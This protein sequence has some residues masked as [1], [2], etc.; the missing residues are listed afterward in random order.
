MENKFG[1]NWTDKKISIVVDYTKA[2][3]T[4]MNKYP[5]F[6]CLY[7]DGFAGSG[8]IKKTR[9]ESEV[10]KG[11]AIRV[12]EID[13]PKEFD[14]YYFVEKKDQFKKQLQEIIKEKFPKKKT[15]VVCGDCNEK[16]FSLSAYLKK[17]KSY[18]VLA[19]IDPFGMSVNWASLQALQGLGIDL[20]ILVPTGI[21]VNRLLKKDGNISEAWLL[22]LENFLGISREEILKNFYRQY[23][24]HNLFDDE[25]VTIQ[26]KEG[27]AI[28]KIHDLY[29]AR[30]ITIFKYVSD[31]FVLRNSNNSIMFH[32]MMATNNP[33]AFK[34]ANEITK[35]AYKL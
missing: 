25:L 6:K 1:G 5:Q 10:K 3:L 32:F 12:L 17:N 18:R 19:F 2:Y 24:Y 26:V 28:K 7:F 35:P 21:G 11:T 29:K 13:Q 16:L 22:K 14:I 31:A 4:I 15:Y 9:K 34:I 8:D 30:L 23:S 20:W 33:S 27:N